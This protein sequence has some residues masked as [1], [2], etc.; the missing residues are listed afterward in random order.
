MWK[1]SAFALLPCLCAAAQMVEGTVIDS[2]Y[3]N[4]L[5]GARVEIAATGAGL[6]GEAAY[7]AVTDSQGRFRIDNVKDGVYVARYRAPGYLYEGDLTPVRP[8]KLWRLETPS[9]W[10]GA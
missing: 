2:T 6:I 3:G 5:A 7:T 8:S 1:L 10:K 4:G 9:L